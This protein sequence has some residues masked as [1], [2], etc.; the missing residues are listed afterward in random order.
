MNYETKNKNYPI[1]FFCCHK[2]SV[3]LLLCLKHSHEPW[4]VSNATLNLNEAF[5]DLLNKS[6]HFY[7]FVNKIASLSKGAITLSHEQA[8]LL[9]LVFHVCLLMSSQFVASVCKFALLFVWTKTILDELLAKLRLLLIRLIV[10]WVLAQTG[11]RVFSRRVRTARRKG[12]VCR[13]RRPWQWQVVWVQGH[14]WATCLHFQLISF[15]FIIMA[16][17]KIIIHRIDLLQL[18]KQSFLKLTEFTVIS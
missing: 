3:G 5:I 11:L 13:F 4:L 8:T 15:L 9:C 2:G 17:Y 7:S 1:S 16:C 14:V 6:L 12:T 10:L 18:I